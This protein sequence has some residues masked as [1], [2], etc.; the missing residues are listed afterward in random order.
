[1]LLLAQSEASLTLLYSFLRDNGCFAADQESELLAIYEK[2]QRT[3]PHL[4][5]D[6]TE[7]K[8][9]IGWLS[10]QTP[11]QRSPQIAR[12]IRDASKGIDPEIIAMI[13]TKVKPR[14]QETAVENGP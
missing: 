6:S 14:L 1:M 4:R 3:H 12:M 11:A 2:L 8:Q 5:S 9:V 13:L 7:G 10:R